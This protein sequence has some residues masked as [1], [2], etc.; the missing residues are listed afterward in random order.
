[1]ARIKAVGGELPPDE[2]S[3]SDML[4]STR[5]AQSKADIPFAVTRKNRF[6]R[7]PRLAVGSP[8]LDV[9]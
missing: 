3:P 6:G 4:R 1:M 7:P 5:R 2:L 8:M 9:T